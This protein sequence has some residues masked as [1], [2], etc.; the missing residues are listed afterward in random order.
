VDWLVERCA[1]GTACLLERCAV[2]PFSLLA[3]V[4]ASGD[5]VRLVPMDARDL[6]RYKRP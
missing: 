5:L 2:A 3:R 6:A 1:P 4:S